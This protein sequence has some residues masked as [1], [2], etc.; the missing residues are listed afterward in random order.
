MSENDF[1]RYNLMV[2]CFTSPP[3]EYFAPEW[4]MVV[5]MINRYLAVVN[6][7][8]NFIIYCVAGKQFR[9]VLSS[10]LKIRRGT[11]LS[12]MAEVNT[13]LAGQGALAHLLQH[14]NY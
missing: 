12:M 3:G 9:S 1:F 13:S 8:I 7:S 5:D 11:S 6:S 10:M 14:S 4:Q 2:E